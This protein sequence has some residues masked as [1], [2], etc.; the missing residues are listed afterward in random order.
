MQA[1][2]CF[3]EKKKKYI[4]GVSQM[5]GMGDLQKKGQNYI[6]W[7]ILVVIVV[8]IIWLIIRRVGG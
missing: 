6:L 3:T 8:L 4:N 2:R 1:R 7:L 5:E